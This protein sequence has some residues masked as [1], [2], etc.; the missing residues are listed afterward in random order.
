MHLP[1]GKVV[2]GG[3]CCCMTDVLNKRGQI[4]A[5]VV[6]DPEEHVRSLRPLLHMREQGTRVV[7]GHD[8]A[9]P[10]LSAQV[11]TPIGASKSVPS[12]GS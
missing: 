4:A 10:A 5:V 7:C 3:D 1:G 9:E 11:P 8:P 6:G 2:L 12:Q